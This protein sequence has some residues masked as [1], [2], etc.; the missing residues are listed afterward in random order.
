EGEAVAPIERWLSERRGGPSSPAGDS[1]GRSQVTVKMPRRGTPAERV[2][3][4]RDNARQNH[5]R[6][7]KRVRERGEK[8]TLALAKALDLDRR[9]ARIEC[10]DISHFQGSSTYASCVVFK[11]GGPAKDEYRVFKFDRPVPD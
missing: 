1:R 2:K 11:D 8:A 6:R 4:A 9:P 10:F 7:F 3:I 5:L